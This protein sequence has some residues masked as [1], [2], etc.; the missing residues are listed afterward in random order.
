MKEILFYISAAMSISF[1]LF[2]LAFYALIGKKENKSDLAVIGPEYFDVPIWR[3]KVKEVIHNDNVHATEMDIIVY[4]KSIFIGFASQ[5]FPFVSIHAGDIIKVHYQ[6]HS[7]S[8][9]VKEG[10]GQS[11]YVTIK[12]AGE[13]PLL[14]FARKAEF[15]AS[16]A[17]KAGLF[18]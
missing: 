18:S 1:L 11:A 7:V 6:R 4:S 9:Q 3:G 13:K 14:Q 16:R 5:G 17:R 2:I 8:I 12:G 15:I 10:N